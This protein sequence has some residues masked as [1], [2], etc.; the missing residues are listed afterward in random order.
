MHDNWVLHRDLKPSNIL[1]EQG[2]LKIAGKNA[3]TLCCA[4][5]SKIS[6]TSC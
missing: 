2:R 3:Y 1:L 4:V 6:P 5:L